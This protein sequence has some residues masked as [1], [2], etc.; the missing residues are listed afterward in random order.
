MRKFISI[1]FISVFCSNAVLAAI[2]CTSTAT[3]ECEPGCFVSSHLG[4]CVQCQAGYYT[5]SKGLSTCNSCVSPPKDANFKSPGTSETGCEWLINCNPGY[6]YVSGEGCQLCSSNT[7]TYQPTIIEGKGASASSTACISC[8]GNSVANDAR[9]TCNCIDN[10]HIKGENNNV[11]K[12]NGVTECVIN[13]YTITYMHDSSTKEQKG[14]EHGES[15]TLLKES[16]S[17][18]TKT[19]YYLDYWRLD[20]PYTTYEPGATI[21]SVT[22]NITLTAIW[23]KKKF[24]VTYNVNGATNCGLTFSE[25]TYDQSGCTAP[26]VKNCTKPGYTF[27]GWICT[28]CNSAVGTIDIG[29]DISMLS[30]GNNMTLTVNWVPC[31]AGYYC[32]DLTKNPSPCPAGSTSDVAKSAKTHCYMTKDTKICDINNNCFTLPDGVSNIYYHGK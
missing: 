19:G 1:I 28:G 8:G 2:T 6:H 15:V 14:I 5:A 13:T 24:T 12:G 7:F 26:D 17:G 30:D 20:N 25:C 3:T 27:G 18:F 32:T 11:T 31:P 9:T 21:S 4:L 23:E 10:Y 29:T 22:S 16:E